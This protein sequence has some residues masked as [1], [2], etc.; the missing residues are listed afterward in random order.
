MTTELSLDPVV[1]ASME[2]MKSAS[3][4]ITNL[5]DNK[6]PVVLLRHNGTMNA[7]AAPF[8]LGHPGE[9]P[10]GISDWAKSDVDRQQRALQIVQPRI[11]VRVVRRTYESDRDRTS[12]PFRNGLRQWLNKRKSS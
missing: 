6:T 7:D 12:A 10:P 4:G 8:I 11:R 9:F 3:C 5:S 2:P 1:G